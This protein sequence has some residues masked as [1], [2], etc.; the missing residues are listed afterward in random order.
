MF[1]NDENLNPVTSFMNF[2]FEFSNFFSL[3][4]SQKKNQF[5]CVDMN[6]F[7]LEYMMMMMMMFMWFV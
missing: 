4:L 3:F 6:V 7:N 5:S 1:V 2:M